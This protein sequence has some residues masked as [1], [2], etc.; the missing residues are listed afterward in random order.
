MAS[1][2]AKLSVFAL[3]LASQACTSAESSMAST[4]WPVYGGDAGHTRFSTLDEI[5]QGNVGDLQIAWRWSTSSLLDPRPEAKMEVTPLAVDGILYAT[6][7]SRRT[8]VAIDGATGETLWTYMLE[9]PE[10]AARAP[11]RGSGRGVAYW[12]DGSEARVFFLT[13]GY[14][15]IALHADTGELVEGF[16]EQF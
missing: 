11:R 1:G 6:A 3:R 4:D 16:A 2:L 9:E 5:D 12:S 10:R 15:L 7:G 13:P 8:V 14:R